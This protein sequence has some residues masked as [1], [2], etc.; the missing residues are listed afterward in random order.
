MVLLV[1]KTI[2]RPLIDMIFAA[3]RVWLV[4]TFRNIELSW[5]KRSIRESMKHDIRVL[6][7]FIMVGF[8]S[9]SQAVAFLC[10][11]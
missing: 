3:A 9:L 2:L 4:E 8:Q 5:F 11:I 6:F 7:V 1:Y 10:N